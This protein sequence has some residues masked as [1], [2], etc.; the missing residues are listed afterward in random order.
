MLLFLYYNFITKIKFAFQVQEQPYFATPVFA[1][2]VN[3]FAVF[4][5]LIVY[6]LFTVFI[7][8]VT[9]KSSN[10]LIG[11]LSIFNEIN[12]LLPSLPIFYDKLFLSKNNVPNLLL[13]SLFSDISD[14]KSTLSALSEQ[15]P[16]NFG[17]LDYWFPNDGT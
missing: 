14:I 16:L 5:F 8:S 15:L 11:P 17:P 9:L 1:L 10:S 7:K 3:I 4:F 2:F 12:S 13:V 6:G